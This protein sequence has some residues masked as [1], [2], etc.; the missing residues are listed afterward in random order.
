MTTE[1]VRE[2]RIASADHSS[3]ANNVVANEYIRLSEPY[4]GL[5]LT[6]NHSVRTDEN[7]K[8]FGRSVAERVHFQHSDESADFKAVKV[9]EVLQATIRD[10]E[11]AEFQSE[12]WDRVE[13]EIAAAIKRHEDRQSVVGI[14]Q[15]N[16]TEKM[17]RNEKP[18][19]GGD[20]PSGIP[21]AYR[22]N[23]QASGEPLTT[24]FVKERYNILGPWLTK[25]A[26]EKE[27]RKFKG[28]RGFVYRW[29]YISSVANGN[30]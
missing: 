23:G 19:T 11:R 24:N 21:P 29:S 1:A 20:K 12:A 27:R 2:L 3:A 5:V 22:N 9:A 17:L 13:H 16:A 28:V 15:P 14:S 26:P 25:K 7:W 30:G 10:F 4:M 18:A 8:A 6:S